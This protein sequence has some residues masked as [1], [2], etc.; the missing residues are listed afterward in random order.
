MTL[1]ILGR[2]LIITFQIFAHFCWW[3]L[4]TCRLA[5]FVCSF[6]HYL[7][8]WHYLEAWN[9]C[10]EYLSHFK[11]SVSPSPVPLDALT[12]QY[13]NGLHCIF[14]VQD[15]RE[16]Q[17]QHFF[18]PCKIASLGSIKC[19]CVPGFLMSIWSALA[20]ALW[21]NLCVFCLSSSKYW[22]SVLLTSIPLLVSVYY[23]FLLFP[24]HDILKCLYVFFV[25]PL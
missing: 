9:Q 6:C 15:F 5:Y 12:S 2:N 21:N 19:G 17:M 11:F 22:L 3:F 18:E 23:A 7:T 20:V 1:V 8:L 25:V 10:S 14:Q 4:V 16:P 24:V 13:S